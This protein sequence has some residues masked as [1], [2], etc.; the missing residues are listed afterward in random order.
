MDFPNSPIP[1]PLNNDNLALSDIPPPLQDGGNNLLDL[2]NA[3]PAEKVNGGSTLPD[4]EFSK[5]PTASAISNPVFH[6]LSDSERYR[7][8]SMFNT[9]G[10]NKGQNNEYKYGERQSWGDVWKNA[11]GG[12]WQIGKNQYI[13][14]WKGWGRMAEA[15]GDWDSNKLIAS[16]PEELAEM[17]AQQESI[18][19][20]Y[21]I[22]STPEKDGTFA[23]QGFGK[24]FNRSFFG[25][26]VQQSGFALGATAQFLTEELIT[27]GLSSAF[28]VAKLGL[29]APGWMGKIVT[30]ADVLKSMTQLGEGVWKSENMM[31]KLVNGAKKFVPLAGTASDIS[32]FS[33]AGAGALQIAA[34]GVGGFKRFLAEA[35]MAMTEAR[36]ESASSY[37]Q[38][39]DNLQNEEMLRTGQ[40][41][42]PLKNSRMQEL[43]MDAAHD[44]FWVNSGI[45]MLSNRIQF[46]NMFKKFSV[47]RAVMGEEGGY[48]A[49]LVKVNGT[50]KLGN[51]LTQV[52]E[53]GKLGAIGTF[54]DIAKTYGVKKAA[55]ETTKNLQK[56]LMKWEVSEG[57][58]ELLQDVSNNTMQNYY[59]DLYH[60]VKGSDMSVSLQKA[61]Q[62]EKQNDQWMSTF[63]MGALTGALISPIT[64]AI[65]SAQSRIGSSKEDR[66]RRKADVKENVD[67]LN[68][69]YSDP[70]QWMN[71]HIANVKIQN[72][73]AQNMDEALANRD[74]Y[75]FKNNRA[76]GFA[77]TISAAIKTDMFESM[78]H[79]L[80]SYSSNFN[81][82]Q[83]KEAFGVEPTATNQKNITAFFSNITD[84]VEAFHK[85]WHSLKERY[86]DLVIPKLYKEGTPER[87][88]A[89]IAKKALDDSIEM[90][91]TIDH[92]SKDAIARALSIKTR[93]ASTPGYGGSAEIAF[94][95]LG[96]EPTAAKELSLLEGEIKGLKEVTPKDKTTRD[97]LKAKEKQYTA[98][99]DWLENLHTLQGEKIT[100]KRKSNR[101]RKGFTEYVNAKNEQSGL[102]LSIKK[103]DFNDTYNDFMDY[104]ELN[105]DYKEAIDAYNILSNPTQFVMMHDR[106]VDAIKET[107]KKFLEE[108]AEEIAAKMV[109]N[110]VPPEK[111]AEV[112]E[113]A[114]K[115]EGDEL[116][117]L[118]KQLEVK[119]TT[120]PKVTDDELEKHLRETYVRL[121]KSAEDQGQTIPEY[122]I[123]KKTAGVYE[124]DRYYKAKRET[125][126]E[127]PTPTSED[128]EG[129][130]M[131]NGRAAN[132]GPYETNGEWMTVEYIF[133]GDKPVD[134]SQDAHDAIRH[135][136]VYN[137]KTKEYK[138]ENGNIISVTRY[139]S[140][141]PKPPA[142]PAP[143]ASGT[144]P[145]STSANIPITSGTISIRLSDSEKYDFSVKNG[146]LI[147]GN[148]REIIKDEFGNETTSTFDVVEKFV[149]K[150]NELVNDPA[151]ANKITTIGIKK[152]EAPK[153]PTPPATGIN[154]EPEATRG[155]YGNVFLLARKIAKGEMPKTP[156]D[157]QLQ[158]NYPKLL[159]KFLQ[160]EQS[161]AA[162]MDELIAKHEQEG[163]FTDEYTEARDAIEEKYKTLARNVIG[164]VKPED[165]DDSA[166]VKDWAQNNDRARKAAMAAASDYAGKT[167]QAGWR[168][169]N[170]SIALGNTTD[171]VN[172]VKTPTFTKYERNGTNPNYHFNVATPNFMPGRAI[173]FRVMT[174]DEEYDYLNENRLTGEKYDRS[175]LFDA[176]GK[177]KPDKFDEVPIAVYTKEGNKDVLIGTVH[178]PLWISYKIDGDYPHIAAP[179]GEDLEAHVKKEVKNN[180]DFRNILIDSFNKNPTFVMVGHISEKSN[181]ILK[182]MDKQGTL[183]DRVHPKIGDG[184][185]KNRHGFFGIVRNG[186]IETYTNIAAEGLVDTETF[187]KNINAYSGSTVLMLPTPTGK[188]MP[189]FVGLPKLDKGKAEFIAEAWKAFTG[190]AV[191]P[192]LVDA[193]YASVNMVRSDQPEIGVLR[194]YIQQYLTRLE[195]EKVS[196]GDGRDIP[197]DYARLYIN[198]DGNLT[199]EAKYPKIDATGRTIT[200]YF[201]KVIRDEKDIPINFIDMLQQL[202]TSIRFPDKKNDA[203][204]GI[205]ST[206]KTTFLSM[207]NGK[208]VK[209]QQTYNQYIMDAATTLVEKGID[210]KNAD[211]DWVYFANPVLQM[212]LVASAPEDIDA[213]PNEP[214]EPGDILETPPVIGDTSAEDLFA[215]LVR[216]GLVDDMTDAQIK[217]EANKC[218]DAFG[219]A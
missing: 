93:V 194:A 18:M 188:Y 103:E 39:Y 119:D 198:D 23:E 74:A 10:Y 16:S 104:M 5:T 205:N 137:T 62:Q 156:E 32:K 195:S 85:T 196:I 4:F 203:L 14:G 206:A 65:S 17:N 145:P 41:V 51:K 135:T 63:I 154:I 139:K 91:A 131:V 70:Y 86:S 144:Q 94:R 146:E 179:Q 88:V 28:S 181:G 158:A 219:D 77:R 120:P 84:Q 60:G 92:K 69:Y 169:I 140:D 171:L 193:V 109:A 13:E 56:G 143:A 164:F 87:E 218:N 192:E 34:I 47:G 118:A 102:D 25:N 201:Y 106:I 160:L 113:E 9:L 107:R 170:P 208:L 90:L 48:A 178:E 138:D 8:S 58:Q 127:S 212:K 15:V 7:N 117:T 142:P 30:K 152:Q 177:V 150:Y 43:A 29:R 141:A 12:A 190:R 200:E 209:K 134:G 202:R 54:G 55:W 126:T 147:S 33:K 204:L 211:D 59:Y 133:E 180:I 61:I 124:T 26:M 159:E 172:V 155:D 175:S 216:E 100:E 81:D 36:M 111:A 136:F 73:V 165:Y 97:L 50:D 68:A 207:D 123:W 162:E 20:K 31:Q 183:K 24:F 168:Q 173:E 176:N 45:L 64:G 3:G 83:F 1:E 153:P 44:N 166:D 129:R 182:L 132:I 213:I 22:F 148:R 151:N 167:Y 79:T 116:L 108:H 210:S 128:K 2:L 38:L 53:K 186:Q 101:A 163:G 157:L 187:G 67:L 112:V 6:K 42:D 21:A 121:K 189:T 174:T 122:E 49:S 72:K 191:N 99:H 76:S 149:D 130:I 75:V 46:D 96:H 66:Q 115:V 57:L 71:E 184:G 114:R 95:T 125:K 82:E 78:M 35:N 215:K 52:Y 214:V 27:M 89:N 185:M 161:K 199:L 110:G 40:A 197:E 19:N 37:G 217:E 98:L 80:K 11:L 105:K